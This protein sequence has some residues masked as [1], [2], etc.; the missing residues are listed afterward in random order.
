MQTTDLLMVCTA[1]RRAMCGQDAV[2]VFIF[3]TLK[4]HCWVRSGRGWRPTILLFCQVLSWSSRMH[5]FGLWKMSL[6]RGEKSVET[7][8]YVRERFAEWSCL[9]GAGV[10]PRWYVI[11]QDSIK[12]MRELMEKLR[13]SQVCAEGTRFLSNF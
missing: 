6:L 12:F 2:T 8:V 7:L 10:S 3:G 5:S 4:E 9:V 11:Y 1:I 13:M